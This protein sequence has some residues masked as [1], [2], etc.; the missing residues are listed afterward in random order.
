MALKDRSRN[1]IISG[2][3]NV[4]PQEVEEVLLLHPKV[5]EVSITDRKHAD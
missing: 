1:M 4:C 2:G 3:S 5:L